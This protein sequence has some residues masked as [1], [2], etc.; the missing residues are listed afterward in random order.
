MH[1]STILPSE[2]ESMTLPL[3]ASSERRREGVPRSTPTT[4]SSPTRFAFNCE[5]FNLGCVGH[6][7]GEVVD[8]RGKEEIREGE[9]NHPDYLHAHVSLR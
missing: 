3:L 6:G 8:S 9:E 5:I 1:N 4:L 2:V 7:F